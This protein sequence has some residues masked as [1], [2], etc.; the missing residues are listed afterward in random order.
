MDWQ[1]E[2]RQRQT[3]RQTDKQ[4]DGHNG[5]RAGSETKTADLEINGR[6]DSETRAADSETKIRKLKTEDS[7]TEEDHGFG[8]YSRRFGN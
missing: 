2:D 6:A 5:S 8:N 4:I 7:E 1:R 3:D